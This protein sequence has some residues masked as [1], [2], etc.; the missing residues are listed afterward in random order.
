MKLSIAMIVKNEEKNIE[1]CLKSFIEIQKKLKSE[2]IVVDTGSSDRTVELAKK[3]TN[4]VFLHKWD[5]NFANMR[6]ISISYCSGEWILIVD[7]DEVLENVEA[8]WRFFE[9]EDCKKVNSASI[10]FKNYSSNIDEKYILGTLFRLFR[11]KNKIEYIG[12]VH[13]QP[14]IV[15]PACNTDITFKHYGYSRSDYK[16]MQ[17]KY[18]RNRD[19][20][21]LDLEENPEDEYTL[22]Q[23]AQTYSMANKEEKA[24]E[25]IE[26]AYEILQTKEYQALYIYHFYARCLMTSQ[27]YLKVIDVC[28]KAFEKG[29]K[30]LDFYYLIGKAYEFQND[31]KNAINYLE[32]YFE[33]RDEMSKD[34]SKLDSTIVSYS[35]SKEQQVIVEI[36]MLYF[37]EFKF[38]KIIDLF[39]S[40]KCTKET[41]EKIKELYFY[42]SMYYGNENNILEYYKDKSLTD[43]DVE[44]IIGDIKKARKEFDDFDYVGFSNKL[45]VLDNRLKSYFKNL[46][47]KT[48][49]ENEFSEIDL[50][51]YYTWKG[52]IF[53]D[54]LKS[55]SKY[56][57]RLSKLTYNDIL[58]YINNSLE[59]YFNIE[60]CIEFT[61]MNFL[62]TDIEGINLT[63]I[64]E[65][66]LI[67]NISIEGVTYEKL[68]YR[69]IINRRN[70]IKRIYKEEFYNGN[71]T[72][73]ISSRVDKFYITLFK[74]LEN[75]KND[76][77]KAIR[78]LKELVKDYS[79]YTKIVD[80]IKDN[81]IEVEITYEMIKEKENICNAVEG[82]INSDSLVEVEEILLELKTTFKFD[83]KILLLLGVIKYMKNE[84][85]DAML[86]FAR[87]L[88]L[89]EK[90][91]DANYNLAV[92]L[93]GSNKIEESKFYYNKA[94]E[95]TDVI[96]EKE[97]ILEII[98]SL[99]KKSVEV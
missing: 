28:N 58:A 36:I 12:R 42:S 47:G 86:F 62:N 54:L 32:K 43:S 89:N 34:I 88:E 98:S 30:N 4:K 11:N 20:L 13:E 79:E 56:I 14:K 23:L 2:I 90:N 77:L 35:Y 50:N 29:A 18:E 49:N 64:I 81:L 57:N 53:S 74:T 95:C 17:Y 87:V 59:D 51:N 10:I 60:K 78:E 82:M 5:G 97:Q 67:R 65:D 48:L 26:K 91:F 41:I 92:L 68:F 15:L 39:E 70:F 37:R 45:L 66:L 25:C 27:A 44:N 83:E 85:S 3:Y 61:E 16:L 46:Y 31:Y 71:F 19:L 6:N 99:N 7:A 76:K 73:I 24:L 80:F 8:V 22:F 69:T 1:R 55:N 33:V 94:I 96:N 38:D 40:A 93:E 63:C 84:I 52:Y 21:L 75:L 9:S 72:N